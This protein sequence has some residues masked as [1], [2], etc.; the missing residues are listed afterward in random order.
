MLTVTSWV[1]NL[2][3]GK[4]G[5]MDATAGKV[6]DAKVVQWIVVCHGGFSDELF[7]GGDSGVMEAVH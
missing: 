7:R 3:G 5:A 6:A 2:V 4:E 1:A